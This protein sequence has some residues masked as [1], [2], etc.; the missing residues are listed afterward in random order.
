M[1]SRNLFFI[2]PKHIAE[3]YFAWLAPLIARV[4]M[5]YSFMMIGWGKLTHLP[6]V[7]KNF[8]G[9]GIPYPQ[10]MAPFVSGWEFL[11]GLFLL[12]GFLT[13]I[14]GAGLA[15]TM[16]VAVVSVQL[17]KVNDLQDFLLLDEVVYFT[18]FSWLAIAGAGKLSLDYLIERERRG[19]RISFN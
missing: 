8:E 1:L 14:S 17:A 6:F 7:I 15:I 9:W 5:G 19:Y 16:I 13:R 18:L 3:T 11:G 10:L 4:V 12:I 2:T